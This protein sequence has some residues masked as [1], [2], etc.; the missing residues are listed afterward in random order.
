MKP[1]TFITG[2]GIAEKKFHGQGQR[3]RT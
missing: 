2:V 3:S 1:A